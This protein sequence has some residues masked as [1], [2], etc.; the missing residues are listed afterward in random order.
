MNPHLQAERAK[1]TFSVPRMTNL[2]DDGGTVRRRYLERLIEDDPVFA[3]ADNSHLSRTN[4]HVR[5]MGKAVRLIELCRELNFGVEKNDGEIMYDVDFWTLVAAVADDPLPISLHWIMFIPN[6]KALCDDEQQSYWLPKCRDYQVIGCYAQT[7]LGHG[8][9]VRGLETTATYSNHGFVIH[10]PTLTATKFWP[11]TLGKTANHAMVIARLIDGE[12]VDRG[13]HNFIVPLRDLKT[14][15]LLPG[16]T[17][18][19]IGPKIG[20]NNMDN[21]YC[22]FKNVWIPR[23]NMAMRFA[24]VDEQGRYY[25]KSSSTGNSTSEDGSGAAAKIAYITMMQVRSMICSSASTYLAMACTIVLRYSAVRH[26]GYGRD[27]T[28]EVPVLDYT[29]QQ[30][31]L[32]PLLAASYGFYFTGQYLHRRLRTV[33][34]HLLQGTAHKLHVTDVHATSSA[35]KSYM[36]TLAADGIEEC[37]RA[38]GGHGFLASSGL[39]ELYT[40]YLQNP[41]VEGDNHMLPQQVIKV[42][43]KLVTAVRRGDGEEYESCDSYGLVPSLQRIIKNGGVSS[44]V[45]TS[46]ATSS[47]KSLLDAF[48]HRSAR[49]LISVAS[50]LQ[51]QIQKGVSPHDAWNQ[52]LVEMARASKAYSQFLIL[53]IFIHDGTTQTPSPHV[54]APEVVVLT[55]MARLLA[56]YWMVQDS[57]DFMEDGYMTSM[58]GARKA[59]MVSLST[60]RT[61]AVPLVDAWDFSDFRLKSTL[62]RYDGN[63]YEAIMEAASREPLNRTDPGPAYE[64]HLKRLIVDGV[65]AA[66]R[67]S[68]L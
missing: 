32:L 4:R 61:N 67:R 48:A 43:L 59:L 7:E 55:D 57:G 46:D 44:N 63:V 3:N 39:P 68:R 35:L 52:G 1:A 33:E 18:G 5:A 54:Q 34:G 14:H 38:C 16:V 10:T 37:R 42:L 20:Y 53:R 27:G 13:I 21:G 23:R 45:R 66:S 30:F 9:N 41:T 47:L 15:Q 64:P 49:L 29:Q 25:K 6:I 36:T 50:L 2:L 22:R 11:G 26:Q 31:R 65:G 12:G 56:L 19:D 62:G 58:D 60:V 17:T 28:M 8:S 51:S 40:T 24:G